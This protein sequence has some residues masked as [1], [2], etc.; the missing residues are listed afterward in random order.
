MS[1]TA[2]AGK[3]NRKTGRVITPG[4]IS[5]IDLILPDDYD[6]AAPAGDLARTDT[7]VPQVQGLPSTA[8][9]PPAPV[10]G[11]SAARMPVYGVSPDEAAALGENLIKAVSEQVEIAG[12][13]VAV[14]VKPSAASSSAS[15]VMAV[16]TSVGPILASI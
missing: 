14:S 2:A 12:S 9:Q 10:P 15:S 8:T 1:R 16:Q 11:G 5:R 7:G 6:R 4:R 13:R 3:V